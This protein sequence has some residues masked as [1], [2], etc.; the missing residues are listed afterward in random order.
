MKSPTNSVTR[1][2]N[3]PMW[4]GQV[5]IRAATTK[6]VPMRFLTGLT[7]LVSGAPAVA[8]DCEQTRDRRVHCTSG[9]RGGQEMRSSAHVRIVL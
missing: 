2:E 5:S 6:Y 1:Y 3:A 9:V 7:M 8:H 4:S